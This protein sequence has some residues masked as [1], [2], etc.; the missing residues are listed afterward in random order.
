MFI[1]S[2]GLGLSK[3]IWDALIPYIDGEMIAKDL[4]GHG[5][6]TESVYDWRSIW[7]NTIQRLSKAEINSASVVLHSFSAGLIPEILECRERPRRIYLVEGIIHPDD[8]LWTKE[9]ASMNSDEYDAWLPRWR[10]VSYMTL[11]SQLILP[12]SRD[13]IIKW[14]SGFKL[15][16]RDALYSMSTRLQSR[17]N[18][19]ELERALVGSGECVTYLQGSRSKIC[20]TA[21]DFVR[22]CGCEVRVVQDSGHFPMLDNPEGLA[23]LLKAE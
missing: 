14:S 13:N 20:Q 21:I 22:R 12:Q 4:P 7:L 15:V 9:I 16:K 23:N 11:K 10:D 1:L 8:A 6:S 19:R 2:H 18:S 17:V 3:N 5:E